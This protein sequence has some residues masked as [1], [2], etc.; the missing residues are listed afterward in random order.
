MILGYT[1]YEIAAL[2]FI[3]G[4]FGWCIEVIYRGLVEQRFVNSGFLNGPICPIYGVGGAIVVICLTPLENNLPLLFIGSVFLTSALEFVTGFALDK[5]FR[6]RWWD[7]TNQPLN[8]CGY[9]CLV[10]S[11]AWGAICV[12]LMKLIHPPVIGLVRIMPFS[13]GVT[14]ISVLTAV[15]IADT[16][17]TV[18]AV[19]HLT[20]HMRGMEELA[21]KIRTVSDNIG[22]KVYDSAKAVAEKGGEILE[23]DEVQELKNRYEAM[24]LES[25]IL[26]RRL[27]KAFPRLRS[28][29]YNDHLE[30]LREKYKKRR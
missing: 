26:Q 9:I 1:I 8:L 5:L 11:L 10:F 2:F 29:S 16:I 7:Y 18:I 3:Y 22:E 14:I 13:L 17:V 6:A 27:I 28:H 12:A 4:F 25:H 15:L 30:K 19:N 24:A 20:S 23:S 21:A